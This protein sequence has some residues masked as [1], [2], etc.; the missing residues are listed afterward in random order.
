MGAHVS[1]TPL[2][3]GP[4]FGTLTFDR[5]WLDYE[6]IPLMFSAVNDRGDTFVFVADDE[7]ETTMTYFVVQIGG[8]GV[9]TV[10]GPRSIRGLFSA[11]DIYRV[12]S[13]W[14]TQ[15]ASHILT[16]LSEAEIPDGAVTIEGDVETGWVLR[17]PNVTP[18]EPAEMPPLVPESLVPHLTYATLQC[19]D[20]LWGLAHEMG[21]DVGWFGRYE[22]PGREYM[23]RTRTMS[24][25]AE[26]I[27]IAAA[28]LETLLRADTESAG[29]TVDEVHAVSSFIH[30]GIQHGTGY[31]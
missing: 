4:P 15:T 11:G 24:E 29:A 7:T 19:R 30:A 22:S 3:S 13:D 17:F 31:S 26:S 9:P 23:A 18:P 28:E 14:D 5:T 10:S 27:E 2:P 1:P 16:E 21:M 8:A 12:V 6:S 25:T 20:R